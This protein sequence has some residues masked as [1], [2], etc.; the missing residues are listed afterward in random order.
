M[1]KLRRLIGL[2]FTVAAPQDGLNDAGSSDRKPIINQN[3]FITAMPSALA[4]ELNRFAADAHQ[5]Y[6]TALAQP[7]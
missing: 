1:P 7:R 4:D 6:A 2:Y 5:W 3:P